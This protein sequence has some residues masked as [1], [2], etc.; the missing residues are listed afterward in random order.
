[1]VFYLYSFSGMSVIE[2]SAA[3]SLL[4]KFLYLSSASKMQVNQLLTALINMSTV[5]VT[6]RKTIVKSA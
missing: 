2:S 5:N 3:A 1:M 6:T 4:A